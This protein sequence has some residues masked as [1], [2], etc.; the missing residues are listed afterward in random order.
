MELL[1]T[2]DEIDRE[3]GGQ[4]FKTRSSQNLPYLTRVVEWMKAARL[5][6]VTGGRLVP[7]KKNAALA[8]RPFDL[9]L[10]MLEAYPRLGQGL[11]PKD[12]WRPSVVG[13]EFAAIGPRSSRCS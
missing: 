9:V 10:A 12:T 13:D 4:L 11:F 8:D 7:V 6:R 2:G 1:G 5:V 3:I